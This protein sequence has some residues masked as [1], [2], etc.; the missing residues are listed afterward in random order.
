MCRRYS[1]AVLCMVAGLALSACAGGMQRSS[2]A[3]ADAAPEIIPFVLTA[4]NNMVVKA[5]LNGT[6]SLDLMLHTAATDVTLTEEAVRRSTSLRFDRAD[7][8]KSWGGSE[9]SRY[10]T[11][12]RLR[13]A[14]REWKDVTV[15][16]DKNSG[17]GTDGKFGLDLFRGKI[18]EIDFERRRIVLYER[19]PA[20]VAGFRKLAFE[21]HNGSMFVRADC[22]IDGV[23]YPHLFLLHSGYAGGVLLDDAFVAETGIDKKLR[24]VDETV[25]KDSF[26]HAIKVRKAVLPA[27]ALG[28]TQLAD[29]QAGFFAGQIGAQRMSVIGGDVLKRFNWIIDAAHG[30]L[31]LRPVG[32]YGS[33]RS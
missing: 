11:G 13:I 5:E 27:F 10:S 24:I 28:G 4:Q 9:T 14:G 8:V 6:D 22:V 20:E 1:L 32:A 7:S 30:E 3:S 18:V 31:Y 25:L 33:Q 12:N 23:A 29:V 15:W 17:H 26:G 16:E 19:L 21:A 2:P